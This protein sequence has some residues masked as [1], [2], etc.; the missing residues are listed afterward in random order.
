MASVSINPLEESFICAKAGWR[1]FG[2]TGFTVNAV[3]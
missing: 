1:P 3:T 2:G